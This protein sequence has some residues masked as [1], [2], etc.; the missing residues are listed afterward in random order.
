[1]NNAMLDGERPRSGWVDLLRIAACFAVV[2][3]HSCDQFVAQFDNDRT[4][5]MTGVLTGSLVRPCV[6]LFVMMTAVL[7]MPVRTGLAEF[8]TKRIGRLVKPLVFWSVALPAAFWAYLNFINPDTQN[9]AIVGDHSAAGTAAKLW[10]WVFNFNFD[11]TPLWYLYM[12]AGLY[13]VMPVFSSWMERA[14]KREIR[15]FL[16]V[17]GVSLLLPYVQMA[18]PMMGYQGNYGN[19]GVYGVC[20]WNQFGTFYYAAGF[21]GYMVLARYMMRFPLKWSWRKTLWTMIPLFA[22]GYAATAAGYIAMQDKFPGNYAYLEIIWYFA[23]ANVF[24]M[25]LP[26]FAIASKLNITPRPWMTKLAALTFG[27]YL[28]HFVFVQA[29]YDLFDI[30]GVPYIVRIA[31]MAV[32]TFAVSA[33]VTAVMKRCKATKIFVS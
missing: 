7:L 23:G 20:D 22:A 1:M 31:A 33:A 29:A 26:V 17:W 13:L 30:E 15:I 18:A 2:V 27:I 21:V 4:A 5:F 9:P 6:P 12:L 3:S 14:E 8:Y 25:T 19:M 10:T 16:G 32:T 28:C 11:T 24:M